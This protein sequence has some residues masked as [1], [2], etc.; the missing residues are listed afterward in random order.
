MKHTSLLN[1]NISS[2]EFLYVPFTC[3]CCCARDDKNLR[4][5][6]LLRILFFCQFTSLEFCR[7]LNK[8]TEKETV[9]LTAKFLGPETAV[10]PAMAVDASVMKVEIASM[11][12]VRVTGTNQDFGVT[13]C[14]KSEVKYEDYE[15]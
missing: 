5:L 1:R 10:Q 14:K 4:A 9:V 6:D 2:M 11:S 7:Q 15:V 3:K 8:K 12:S 13:I